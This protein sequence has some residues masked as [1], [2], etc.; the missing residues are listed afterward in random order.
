LVEIQDKLGSR[1]R[2]VCICREHNVSFPR[3]METS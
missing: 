2:S 1:F 3:I